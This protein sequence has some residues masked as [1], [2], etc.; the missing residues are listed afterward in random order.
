MLV[1][2]RMALDSQPAQR[3]SQKALDRLI[4]NRLR[5]LAFLRQRVASDEIAEDILQA[6]FVK[7][8]E[9][10]GSLRD[11]E[12]DIAWFYRL[13]RNAT[14]DYYRQRGSS[15]RALEAFVHELEAQQEQMFLSTAKSA[16]ACPDSSK[17]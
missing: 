14:V 13:L 3:L 11:Q 5:F 1:L 9:K 10:G 7:G 15:E 12:T 16:G 6:A 8:I 17:Y 4:E 2:E